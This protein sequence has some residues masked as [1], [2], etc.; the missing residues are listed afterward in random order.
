MS[1]SRVRLCSVCATA[2]AAMRSVDYCFGCWPGGPVVP[3]PCLRCGARSR[4]FTAGLCARCHHLGFGA[5]QSCQDCLAWGANGGGAGLCRAC[6]SWRRNNHHIA[7]CPTCGRTLTLGRDGVCRLCFR[8]AA[9]QREPG[10]PLDVFGANKHGQ[11]L[12]FVDMFQDN[13]LRDPP[14]RADAPAGE[15]A[16]VRRAD[17]QVAHQP[18][19][20]TMRRDLAAHGRAGLHLRADPARYAALAP[21]IAEV[22]AAANWSAQHHEEATI[23]LR[24]VLGIQ[25]A[26]TGPINASD[27]A[28]LK[29]INLPVWTVLAVLSHAGLLIED[30]T[31][32]LDAWFA[33]QVHD[34]PEPMTTQLRTWFEVMKNGTLRSPRRRPRTPGTIALHLRWSLP[35]LH[36]WAATGHTDLRAITKDDVL[37]ALVAS[38]NPRARTGQGLKSIFRLLKA[39]K[40]VFTDPTSRVKTGEHER[41]QPLPADVT[42]LRQALASPMP[43]TAALVALI[44]FHGLRLGQLQRLLLTDVQDGRLNLPSRTI[45]LADPVR[46]RLSTYLT[47]RNDRWPM[48]DNPHLFVNLRTARRGTTV[49]SRWLRLAVGPGLTPSG[50]REDRILDEATANGG[51]I[52]A[53]ADLFGLS[54]SA[55]TRYATTLDATDLAPGSPTGGHH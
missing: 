31:P 2:P 27:V 34:L 15:P 19:L 4:Y 46:Q 42:L 44:A 9:S 48:T 13:T 49:G 55:T 14:Q 6:R 39:R 11:Q 25:D 35:T 47:H 32:A 38:A 26:P 20:F 22:A 7:R 45:V 18:V 28:L 30:R 37:D 5:A 33:Q 36:A 53:L 10:V 40:V 51:D 1:S 29:D 50:I 8:H 52:R 24:I 3:P 17:G 43:A 54:L 21:V 41:R 12:F 16:R 23:G